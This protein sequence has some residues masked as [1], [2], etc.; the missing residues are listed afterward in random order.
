MELS[1]PEMTFPPI[2]PNFKLGWDSSQA[3][4]PGHDYGRGQMAGG[5]TIFA[6]DILK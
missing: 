6:E 2:I 1:F 3:G 5:R 4:G